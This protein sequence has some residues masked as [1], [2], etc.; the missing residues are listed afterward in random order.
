MI[1]KLKFGKLSLYR[2]NW[3]LFQII[4]TFIVFDGLRDQLKFGNYI[5]QLKELTTL[6]LFI[7]TLI[8]NKF[9]LKLKIF[10]VAI[11]LFYLYHLVLGI[12]SIAGGLITNKWSVIFYYKYFQFFMLIYAFYYFEELTNKKY[13][14]LFK[15][16]VGLCCFFILINIVAY[17]VY[18][19]VFEKFRPWFGRI[20]TAY[21]TMDVIT[22]SYSFVLFI[23]L[24]NKFGYSKVK[25]LVI[26]SILILGIILQMTGTGFVIIGMLILGLFISHFNFFKIRWQSTQRLF[27]KSS[28]L[29]I[30]LLSLSVLYISKAYPDVYNKVY[31]LGKLKIDILLGNNIGSQANTLEYRDIQFNNAYEKFCDTSVKRMFGI[32]YDK[33]NLQRVTSSVVYIEDQYGINLVAMGYLGSFIF[34]LIFCVIIVEALFIKKYDFELFWIIILSLGIFIINCKTLITLYLFSN[35]SY[36][37]L[38]YAWFKKK[39]DSYRCSLD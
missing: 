28:L 37:A 31:G 23:F 10:N 26:I 22:L 19:P 35:F 6:V 16:L 29:G 33:I 17:V 39:K 3:I 12:P 20:S 9:S 25:N 7:I 4:I 15:R 32:G 2:I 11:L 5:S 1:H 24:H 8:K 38:I 34:Y 14:I 21:P 18:I 36:F 13:L 30:I 27:W